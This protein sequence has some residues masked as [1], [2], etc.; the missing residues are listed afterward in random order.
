MLVDRQRL[1]QAKVSQLDGA[2]VVDETRPAC[3]A[4]CTYNK[5]AI[6]GNAVNSKNILRVAQTGSDATDISLDIK[7]NMSSVCS[8]MTLA[9]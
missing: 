1:G 6:R 8:D 2:S 5:T 4:G 9:V 3:N 7:A